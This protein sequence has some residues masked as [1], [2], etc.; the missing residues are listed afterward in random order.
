MTAVIALQEYSI[1]YFV[2]RCIYFDDLV[3][4]SSVRI[5]D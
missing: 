4:A 3:T 1:K 2:N 5:S